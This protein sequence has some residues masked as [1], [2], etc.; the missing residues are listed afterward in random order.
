LFLDCDDQVLARRYKETRR[1][2]PLVSIGLNTIN[3]AIAAERELLKTLF[4]RSDYLINTTY[5]S[6][7][8]LK[9]RRQPNYLRPRS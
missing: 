8:Q 5:L 7:A 3:D 2:H 1:Q 6:P 9:E 4:D